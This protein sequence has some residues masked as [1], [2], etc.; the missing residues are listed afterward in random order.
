MSGDKA[1]DNCQATGR[2]TNRQAAGR[3]PRGRSCKRELS[4]RLSKRPFHFGAELSNIP[5]GGREERIW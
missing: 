4:E 3:E 1:W 5:Q 2:W